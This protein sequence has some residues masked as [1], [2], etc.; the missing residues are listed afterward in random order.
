MNKFK[1]KFQNYFCNENNS[2]ASHNRLTSGQKIINFMSAM[3]CKEINIQGSLNNTLKQ[4]VP[5]GGNIHFVK[6]CV[7]FM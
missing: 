2:T 7:V 4:F 5:L 3:A 6:Y 1:D